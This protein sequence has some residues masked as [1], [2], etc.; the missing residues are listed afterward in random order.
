MQR[1]AKTSRAKASSPGEA[2]RAAHMLEELEA[3]GFKLTSQRRA[4]VELFAADL[5]HPTAQE[6]FERLRAKFPSMS[7]ATVYNTLDALTQ[8]GLTATLRM[9]TAARFDPNTTPHHHAVCGS[10]GRILDIPAETLAPTPAA[11][12]RLR[13]KAR[14]FEVHAVERIYRGTCAACVDKSRASAR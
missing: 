2:A 11:V 6:L 13:T 9:G 3:A 5:T 8:A 10:C 12:R 7:F 1:L 14:G 4:I